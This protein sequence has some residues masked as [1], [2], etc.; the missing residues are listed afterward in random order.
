MSADLVLDVPATSIGLRSCQDAVLASGTRSKL[1]RDMIS[2]LQIVVEELFSNTIKYGY[3]GEC[4]RPV[5]IRLRCA[6][7]IELVYED[8]APPFDPTLWQ[9]PPPPPGGI[10]RKGIVLVRGLAA[11]VRYERLRE[12]NRVTLGFA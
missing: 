4:E 2:R 12:G 9:E 1:P 3:G 5:R 8:A 6:P 11:S 10:G 7:P